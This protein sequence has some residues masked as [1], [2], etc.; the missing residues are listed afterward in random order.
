[1]QRTWIKEA[2]RR[3]VRNQTAATWERILN[4]RKELLR[5]GGTEA[6]PQQSSRNRE[7]STR[8]RISQYHVYIKEAESGKWLDTERGVRNDECR[9]NSA[10]LRV[11]C[12]RGMTG[13]SMRVD[14]MLRK[15]EGGCMRGMTGWNV[16]WRLAHSYK[17]STLVNTTIKTYHFICNYRLF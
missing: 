3:E 17:M 15:L 2:W 14:K 4:T 16:K 13:W 9:D 6:A 7:A 5:G 10:T 8:T 12:L 11:G 1:M